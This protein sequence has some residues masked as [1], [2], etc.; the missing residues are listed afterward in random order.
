[1]SKQPLIG[2][3]GALVAVLAIL[4]VLGPSVAALID[5]LAR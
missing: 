1:M 3:D 5:R 4:W 2:N